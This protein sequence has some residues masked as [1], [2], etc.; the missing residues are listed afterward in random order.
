MTPAAGE[1]DTASASKS[2]SSAD[3]SKPEP[4]VIED[5]SVDPR[6]SGTAQYDHE[7]KR[8]PAC[9]CALSSTVVCEHEWQKNTRN[10]FN[11]GPGSFQFGVT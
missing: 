8:A 6:L 1:S 9:T 5:T 11:N 3:S 4:P 7:G 10:K 2:K